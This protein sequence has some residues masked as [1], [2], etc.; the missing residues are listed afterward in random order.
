MVEGSD[1]G[2][3]NIRISLKIL[4]FRKMGQHLVYRIAK[5]YEFENEFEDV[6]GPG[7]DLGSQPWINRNVGEASIKFG[8][9]LQC[10]LICVCK[11]PAG[12]AMFLEM[13]TQVDIVGDKFGVAC[14]IKPW[15]KAE[16]GSL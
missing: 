3:L 15:I 14:R 1:S 2:F 9:M 7:V 5:R 6:F 11:Q 10:F 8:Q 12:L 4:S 13:S 16:L